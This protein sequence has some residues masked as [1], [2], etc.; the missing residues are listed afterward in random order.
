MRINVQAIF[1]DH[2]SRIWNAS[3]CPTLNSSCNSDN[4]GVCVGNPARVGTE[5]ATDDLPIGQDFDDNFSRL[6]H[7]PLLTDAG[8]F[9]AAHGLSRFPETADLSHGTGAPGRD[10]ETVRG[11][12]RLDPPN[13]ETCPVVPLVTSSDDSSLEVIGFDPVTKVRPNDGK[14]DA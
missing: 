2:C 11:S 5:N 4:G 1:E 3:S 13:L 14:V 9:G 10:S 12:A 6:T 7:Q 8:S